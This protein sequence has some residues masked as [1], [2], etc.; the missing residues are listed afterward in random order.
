MIDLKL[1][2]KNYYKCQKKKD[3]RKGEKK[4]L[5]CAWCIAIANDYSQVPME[6]QAIKWNKKKFVTAFFYHD[7]FKLNGHQ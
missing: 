6:V 4:P 1:L 2:L 3:K 7:C 5:Y